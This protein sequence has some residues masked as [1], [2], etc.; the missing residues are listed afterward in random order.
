MVK[1]SNRPSL[2]PEERLVIAL[3]FLATGETFRS[4]AYR[5]RVGRQTVHNVVRET[6]KTIYDTLAPSYLRMPQTQEEWLRIAND[7][8]QRWNLPHALGMSS[9]CNKVHIF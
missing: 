9:R 6:C 4:L 7:F 3:R 8:E 1:E 5:F 2:C